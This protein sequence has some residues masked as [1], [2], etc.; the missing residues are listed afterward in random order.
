MARSRLSAC[1]TRAASRTS[2][3]KDIMSEDEYSTRLASTLID[4]GATITKAVERLE[5]AGTGALLLVTGDRRLCGLLVDGDVRRAL[6]RGVPFD[7][8][9]SSIATA[10]PVCAN[11]GTAAVEALRIM[12]EHNVNH[13]PVVDS[14]GRLAGLLLRRDLVRDDTVPVAAVIMAGGFGTRLRPLTDQVPKPM[15]PVGDQP[16]LERTIGRLREAGIRQINVTTHHLADSI[17]SYFGDG[18]AHG[19]EIR[20]V[21]E[22]RPLGTCG[23]LKFVEETNGPLLVINGDILTGINFGE[24]VAFHRRHSADATVCVRKYDVHVPY[25]VVECDGAW[26]QAIRE[27]PS[28][29]FFVNAGIYLLEPVVQRYIPEG[30]RFDMPDLINRLV[31]DSRCVASFP[32]RG[33]LARRRATCRLRAGAARRRDHENPMNVLI[34]GGAGYVGSTL[35]PRLLATGHGVRVL[36]T[37]L[38]GG[39]ALL[40]VWSHPRFEFVRGDVR[41]RAAVARAL[42]GIDAVVHLAAIVG[43]PACARQPELAREVNL[44]ASLGLL[45]EARRRSV[46][47]FVFASTCSNY[48]KMKD[49]DSYVDEA[50][51][52]APVSLYAETKVAVE[53]ALLGGSV[54]NGFC[55]TVLRFATVY[56][57]SPR[58]RFD[59]TVNEFTLEMVGRGKLVVFGE[60]FWRPYVHVVDAARALATVLDA[61]GS[62]VRRE[63]FNVG[64]TNQNY[65]KL[66]LVDLVRPYAPDAS[67]EFV[68][69]KEDPRDYRVSFAKVK[70]RLDFTLTKVR[71]R[72]DCRGGAA[73]PRRRAVGP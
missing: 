20:Y 54:T 49:T 32:D 11:E 6:L 26:L 9:C 8:P 3:L 28:V 2:L 37:L 16:L 69:K 61:L 63:V 46:S 62:V 21:S 56:G 70:E 67:V 66:D 52:L 30:E 57:V 38:H 18:R 41:D 5:Q 22:K 23:G 33:V 17:M 35:A 10:D 4:P 68:Q 34:T 39:R 31:A 15:L 58:M 55:P 13:L 72:W 45:A 71:P 65:R 1:G 29:N 73:R 36:D 47:R 50:S 7:Q 43:D 60:Q 44:E 14:G 12:N 40:P 19:V 59:L 53:R 64:A 51:E 25:G 48:G 27:K 42:D 24:L